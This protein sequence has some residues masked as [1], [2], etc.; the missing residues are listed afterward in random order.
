MRAFRDALGK[1]SLNDASLLYVEVSARW[2]WFRC[3]FLGL[4]HMEIFIQ[5]RSGM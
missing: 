2:L 1:L 5:E 4:L 3:G